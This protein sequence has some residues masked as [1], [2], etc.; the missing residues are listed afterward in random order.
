MGAVYRAQPRDAAA[1]DRGEAAA[2]RT[3]RAPSSWQRFEREV[4]LT[5]PLTHPNTVAIF[6]YGRTAGRRLLLRDG[7][8]RGHEPRRPRPARRSPARGARRARPPAGRGLARRGPRGGPH[9]PRRQAGQHHPVPA[10]RRAR[11]RQGRRLRPGQGPGPAT[12]DAL[13]RTTR[14]RALRSIWPPRPSPLPAR[15]DARSDLYAL[16]C[17]GYYLL[18]GR[19]VFEGRNDDGGLRPPPAHAAHAAGG[20]PGPAGARG[21]VGS[22]SRL[23]REGARPAPL[24]RRGV[25]GRSRR[26]QGRRAVDDRA[27]SGLVGRAGISGRGAGTRGGAGSTGARSPGGRT[28]PSTRG[29]SSAAPDRPPEARSGSRRSG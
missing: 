1:A 14:S 22:P 28:R 13:A 16:G 7:V 26:S 19:H 29:R 17:V 24:L 25:P 27:G 2:A 10:R 4:Q 3:R 12:T 9:P 6:D 11:R 8:P 23:P 15:S 21:A 5:E 18:T 20:A